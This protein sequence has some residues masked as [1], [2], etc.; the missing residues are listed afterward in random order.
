MISK[1]SASKLFVLAFLGRGLLCWFSGLAL[2]GGGRWGAA[3]REAGLGVK[4]LQNPLGGPVFLP[5]DFQCWWVCGMNMVAPH[6]LAQELKTHIP[7]SSRNPHRRAVNHS[8]LP[9]CHQNPVFTLCPSFFTSGMHLSFKTPN[10]TDFCGTDLRW[11][12]GEGLYTILQD[13]LHPH[14][15]T[16]CMIQ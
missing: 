10:F 14:F 7:H 4:H 9:S 3:A 5:E 12:L 2:S 15:L 8:C 16:G 6:S 13:P 11:F 1:L